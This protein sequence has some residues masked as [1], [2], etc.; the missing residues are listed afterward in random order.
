MTWTIKAESGEKRTVDSRAEAESV[1]NDMEQLGMNCKIIS[2]DETKTDGG[3]AET[4]DSPRVIPDGEILP[5]DYDE[6]NH[7]ETESDDGDGAGG[8]A[9]NIPENPDIDK[10]PVEWLPDHLIDI[11]EGVPTISRKGYCIVCQQYGVSIESESIVR[12]SDTEFEYAEFRA[13]AVD[14]DGKAYSGFGTAH[15]ERGDDPYLL[16][17]LA[18]T[19]AMKRAATWATGVGL[20]AV[21]EME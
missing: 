6:P 2:P 7:P 20:T 11:V 19:R 13:V 8:S 5:H 18:E 9:A 14:S 15:V 10:N 17:E 4:D 12:S 3:Q 21:E 16:N 1:R